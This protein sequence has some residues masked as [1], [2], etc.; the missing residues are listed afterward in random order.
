MSTKKSL[1]L[2]TLLATGLLLAACQS[3]DSHSKT[4]SSKVRPV[5]HHSKK[6]TKTSSSSGIP[7]KQTKASTGQ[8]SSVTVQESGKTAVSSTQTAPASSPQSSS[9]SSPTPS[10]NA[11]KSEKRVA[12]PAVAPG[13]AAGQWKNQATG[14]VSKI[15]SDGQFADST[16]VVSGVENGPGGQ[17]I[18]HVTDTVFVGG[19]AFYYYPAGVSI[20][21]QLVK[22]VDGQTVLEPI[23]DPTD[24]T[25]ERIVV[26]N[27]NHLQVT[28]EQYDQYSSH[29]LYR[30]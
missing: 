29:I 9:A 17:M 5:T 21:V 10:S 4:D 16:L 28:Q 11:A 23:T 27:A 8:S 6:I 30:P 12:I 2:V 13:V 18:L 24:T 22:V 7:K 25:K 26:S 3:N 19:V 15:N 20:P 14:Q 1:S